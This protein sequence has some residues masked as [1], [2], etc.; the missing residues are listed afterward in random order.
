MSGLKRVNQ[1][2]HDA[3][4]RVGWEQLETL[5]ADYYRAQ[6]YDVEHVGTGASGTRF[7]GGVDLKLR[8][9]G[10]LTLVQCKHWNAMKVPHNAVH[11]LLG[12]LVN[13]GATG[14]ILVTSGEFSRA[15]IAAAGR[16]GRVELVDG[17]MLRTMVGPIP[18]PVVEVVIGELQDDVAD[19]PLP[20]AG[21]LGE[22]LLLAAGGHLRHARRTPDPNA[23]ID[24]VLWTLGLKLAAGFALLLVVS[25]AIDRAVHPLLQPVRMHRLVG[26]H[27]MPAAS[28][29]AEGDVAQAADA[30]ATEPQQAADPS[31]DPWH[32]PTDAEIREQPR[33][34][35]AAMDVIK[36]STPEL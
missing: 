21:G 36:D 15:A 26:L 3:L 32:E 5:L 30:D 12:I 1:R 17:A 19:A 2:R 31:S 18:E 29:L 4:S 16:Q 14:A 13:Q 33:K 28:P 35:D 24:A 22:R 8:R 6:G 11:E 23:P 20:A 7:D 34:A 10:A 25:W 9:D 27:P